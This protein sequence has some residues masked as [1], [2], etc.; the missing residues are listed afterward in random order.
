MAV[1]LSYVCERTRE[2][3]QQQHSLTFHNLIINKAFSWKGLYF[4]K[5]IIQIIIFL[6]NNYEHRLINVNYEYKYDSIRAQLPKNTHKRR[7]PIKPPTLINKIPSESLAQ[8]S[9]RDWETSLC[10]R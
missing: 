3:E 2:E 9:N 5:K 7:I 4:H 10:M 1:K 6:I 8:I